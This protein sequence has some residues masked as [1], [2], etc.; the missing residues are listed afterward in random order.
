MWQNEDSAD[1]MAEAIFNNDLWLADKM[2]SL[3]QV[4]PSP[5][6]VDIALMDDNAQMMELLLSYDDMDINYRN[7]NGDT[8]LM[9]A[10][11]MGHFDCV[12]KLVDMGIH[13]IYGDFTNDEAIKGYLVGARARRQRR[14]NGLIRCVPMMMLWRKRAT[15][16]VFHPSRIDFISDISSWHHQSTSWN[17]SGPPLLPR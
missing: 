9:L 11:H 7:E 10:C 12:K 6:L 14:I 17:S 3:C 8:Y 16:A 2:L 1:Q 4:D 13:D 5:H 15:E